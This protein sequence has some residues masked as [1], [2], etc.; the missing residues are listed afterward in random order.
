MVVGCVDLC[1]V[2]CGAAAGME[3]E[4]DVALLATNCDRDEMGM[5]NGV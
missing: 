4:A 5:G 3:N 2:Q 1:G